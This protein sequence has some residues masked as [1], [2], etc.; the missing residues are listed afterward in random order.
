[1]TVQ[2]HDKNL[3]VLNLQL[4]QDHRLKLNMEKLK[5]RQIEVSFIG[6]IAISEGLQVEP[7]KVETICNMPVPTDKV[8]VQRLL[9]KVQYL[10]KFLPNLAAVTNPSREVTQNDVEWHWQDAQDTAINRSKL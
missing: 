9:G 6:H 1:M 7:A 3:M 8:G 2:D 4:W 10:S 5:L